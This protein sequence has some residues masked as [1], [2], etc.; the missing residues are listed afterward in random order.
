MASGG[1]ARVRQHIESLMTTITKAC[2]LLEHPFRDAPDNLNEVYRLLDTARANWKPAYVAKVNDLVMAD[3]V[4][5][6][7]VCFGR[8]V[9]PGN[10]G[11][12][13]VNIWNPTTKQWWRTVAATVR[14]ATNSEVDQHRAAGC[15]V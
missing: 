8:Y 15:Q 13:V 11:G 9:E 5:C 7:A 14:P 4:T 3:L 10:V 12:H 1:R 2:E 6:D